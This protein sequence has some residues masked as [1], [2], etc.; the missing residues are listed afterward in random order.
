[1]RVQVLRLCSV[2]LFFPCLCLPRWPLA[3]ATNSIYILKSFSYSMGKLCNHVMSVKNFV[4]LAHKANVKVKS[5]D[6]SFHL[7]NINHKYN[8]WQQWFSLYYAL[9]CF[10]HNASTRKYLR[11]CINQNILTHDINAS[12]Y[13]CW[14]K[15]IKNMIT[16]LINIDILLRLNFLIEFNNS[17]TKID[18]ISLL[19]TQC[20]KLLA[21]NVFKNPKCS[22]RFQTTSPIIIY[23]KIYE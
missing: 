8:F 17:N 22:A 7:V 15:K 23:L 10:I 6:N 4:V 13:I 18:S 20:V 14:R 12:F 1:M 19:R 21:G 3:R 16:N 2:F 9:V 5:I 11:S